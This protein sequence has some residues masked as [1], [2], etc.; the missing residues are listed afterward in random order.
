MKRLLLGVGAL[1][2]AGGGVAFSLAQGPGVE[3]RDLSGLVGDPDRGVYVARLGGCVACHTDAKNG[4]AVLAGGGPI[5]TDFGTFFGPNITPHA[6]DGVG[7][8]TL[9]EFAAAMTA[10]EAPDGSSYYPVFPYDHYTRMTD[11]DIVDL[12]VGIRTVPAVAGQA[13]KHDLRFPFSL[14]YAAGFWRSLFL[15]QGEF[16]PLVEEDPIDA[17]G[18]YLAEGPGHCGACHSPRNVLGGVDH[19]NV[20]G[21]G[22]GPSGEKIPAISKAALSKDGWTEADIAYA[23]RTGVTPSG[24]VFGGSM[25]EVVRAGTQFWSDDDQQAIARFFLNTD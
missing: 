12:W 3:P 24:D 2:I 20:H 10:G 22:E 4:G 14:R 9:E 7:S 1:I 11:Q 8:W 13:A 16:E 15:D 21:G 17:R 6:E 23:L 19:R 18:R 25:A 5:K